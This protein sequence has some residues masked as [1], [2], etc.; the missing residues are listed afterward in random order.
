M[1]T[2]SFLV[3]ACVMAVVSWLVAGGCA[4]KLPEGLL[5]DA[6]G[7]APLAQYNLGLR[8]AKGKGV[9][10][11]P[12]AAADWYRKA[13]EQGFA[14]AQYSLG[15]AYDQGAGVPQDRYEAVKWHRRAAEQGFAL[16]QYS[17]GLAYK[18]G[19]GV[20]RDNVLAHKWANLAASRSTGDVREMALNLRE[21]T[22][23]VMTPAEITEAQRL[24][25]EWR[26]TTEVGE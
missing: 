26:P 10:E 1:K 17:L 25:S 4:K 18:E 11:D 16:A 6:E 21:L 14:L 22:S 7:G 3:L 23:W 2:T 19:D 5:E 12:V 24:A 15:S 20:P 13:A 9:P 8:Y